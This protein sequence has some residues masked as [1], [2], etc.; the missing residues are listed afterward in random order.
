M[1]GRGF[2]RSGDYPG[3]VMLLIDGHQANDNLYN[4]SYLGNDGLI[5]TELIDRV[6]Y[7]S[8][9]GSVIYGN[10][11]FYGIINVITKKGNY[12]DG[13]QIAV[14]A[15]SHDG[16]R[17]RLTYGK[18][19]SN[20]ADILFSTSGY[21]SEGQNLYFSEFD[22]PANNNGIAKDL[23][24]EKNG[25]LFF[26]G[27]YQDWSLEAAYVKRKKNDPAAGYGV[28]F[29]SDPNYMQDTNAYINLGYEAEISDN[30]KNAV[31]LY[32]GQY[33][34]E[35]RATY[36][37]E[38]YTEND[39]GRWWGAETKFVTTA[40]DH[41]TI[42]FGLEYRNDF[43]QDFYLQSGNIEHSSY[44]VSAYA[45]D[46][47]RWNK[48]WAVNLGARLDYGGENSKNV[49]PRLAVIYSPTDSI[50]V[51]ASYAT[52]FRRP[53][54]YEEYY[55]DGSTQIG[56][57]DLDKEQVRAGEIVFEYRPD[58]K[59]KLLSS[60]YLYKTKNLIAVTD[61]IVSPGFLQASNW[62]HHKTRGMDFEFEKKFDATSLIRASYAWQF[63]SNESG[64]WIENS[65]KHLA[66]VNYTHG[67]FN[68]NVH[69]GLEVQYIGPRKTEQRDTLGG[70]TVTNLTLYNNT[71]IKNTTISASV[72]N[73]FDKNYAVPSPGFYLP[74]SF[75]QDDQNFWLQLS[76]DFK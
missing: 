69:L 25:R 75:D 73:L 21:H 16:Y 60:F 5:S 62:D 66:K 33:M 55:D 54:A 4:A 1:S 35:N 11:A 34:Y 27:S 57:T 39:I 30:F 46:E 31:K 43:Q 52:A 65:P 13:V 19:L 23:D 61:S 41:Q 45:Q 47:Y 64:D 74:D 76:Y 28:D 51:K 68:D 50:D 15:E 9:P 8:G 20:G 7:V 17:G 2:G 22:N 32:Y 29:N 3:R 71:W 48:Y 42:V 49:S 12:F 58:N 38:L 72:K 26:K 59:T 36:S 37:G 70:Y 56:N 10:G 24:T 6:E 67:L 14:D 63:A 53:N 18:K 44:M 40:F